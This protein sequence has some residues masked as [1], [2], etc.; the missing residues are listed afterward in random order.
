VN[1]DPA[2][3]REWQER[4]ARRYAESLRAK[5]P[6]RLSKVGARK[7]R[8]RP[9]EAAFRAALQRRSHGFCEV[10]TP[11]CPP[12]RHE[13]HD[14]HHIFTSDRAK[15]IHDPDRGLWVCRLGHDWI[16]LHPALAREQGWAKRDGDL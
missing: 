12:H 5:P 6:K 3:I 1:R 2:A 16:G 14:P 7:L 9:D 13:G 8:A 15:G 11:A 4:S 10:S